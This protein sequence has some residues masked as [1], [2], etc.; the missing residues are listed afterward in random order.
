MTL[1]RSP[2]RD[3]AIEA[4]LPF[5][6]EGGW[7]VATLRRAAG[8]DADLLFPGGA[9]E[10]A[11]A[12]ADLADR[13]MEV[14]AASVDMSAMRVPARVRTVIAGRLARNEPHKDAV[15]RALAVLGLPNQAARAAATLGRTV[16]A[17]WRAAG[18][19]SGG[20]TWFTKRLTLSAVYGSTLLFWLQDSS[21]EAEDTLL[22]LDR[23]LAGVGRVTRLRSRATGML[24]RG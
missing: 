10:M 23:R 13:W 5:V 19:E 22:F 1:E 11:E 21:L 7:S 4:M 18:D 17:I 3:E 12:F 6:P 14:D 8:P 20:V 15:R 24:G 16:D 2:E 9:P